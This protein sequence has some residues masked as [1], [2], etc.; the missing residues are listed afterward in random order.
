M[1]D[2]IISEKQLNQFKLII[3]V[4]K[5]TTK[6][7]KPDNWKR[8]SNTEIWYWMIGQVMV[9]GSAGGGKRFWQS[10]ELKKEVDFDTL[11]KKRS[12]KAIKKSIHYVLREAGARY[13]SIELD[14]CAKTKALHSNFKVV[15][16]Y[17]NG[18]KDLLKLLHN[19][20]GSNRELD[21]VYFLMDNLEFMK[22]KSARD[23]LMNLGMNQNTLAID[24]RIQNIFQH[25]KIGFPS[26]AAFG[27]RIVYESIEEAIKNS[28][29]QPLKIK[30]LH[31]DRILY[32]NYF[33]I[34]QSDYYQ[35]KL[36]L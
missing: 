27:N 9:V 5:N 25:L 34:L 2:L 14:K 12:D 17:K 31:F 35:I 26:Q 16:E 1:K 20:R 32:Q 28:I 13:A 29:C 18:F 8:L 33:R 23:F 11:L 7:P 30:P 19:M 4:Y 6:Y 24:I 22:N 21:R 15:K 3:D 36:K 10:P